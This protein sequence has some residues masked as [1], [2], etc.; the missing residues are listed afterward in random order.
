MYFIKNFVYG[1]SSTYEDPFHFTKY[2][3]DLMI[4]TKKLFIRSKG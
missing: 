4:N 1:L 3:Y 2:K